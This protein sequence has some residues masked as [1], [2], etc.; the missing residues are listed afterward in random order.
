MEIN[1]DDRYTWKVK[2]PC[3]CEEIRTLKGTLED[4]FIC[5]NAL[6]G[7]QARAGIMLANPKSFKKAYSF[8]LN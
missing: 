5:K 4:Y 8:N 7:S 3:G 6:Y 1:D 2:C